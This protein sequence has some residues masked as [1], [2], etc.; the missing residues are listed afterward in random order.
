MRQFQS[1]VLLLVLLT[2][3]FFGQPVRAQSNDAEQIEDLLNQMEQ[4]VVAGDKDTYMT[5]IDQTDPVFALEHSRWA[6][7]WVEL[8]PIKRFDLV[9]DDLEISADAATAEL[10]MIWELQEDPRAQAATFAVNFRRNDAGQW[11]Y[12]GE[13]WA[14]VETENF[15]VRYVEGEGDIADRVVE[16]LPD[17]FSHTTT[18]LDYAPTNVNEIKLYDSREAL[19]ANTLLSLPPISGWNEPEEALKLY[20]GDM[21]A[22]RLQFVLVHEF[23]HKLTFD[24]ANNTHGY[25]SWW[26]EEGI[27]QYI[28]YQL[29]PDEDQD[30]YLLI[31][32]EWAQEDALADWD[33]ITDFANTPLDLWEYVYP[34]GYAM[35]RYVTETYGND[36]RNEWIRA[37]GGDMRLDEAT[38]TILGVEF[39]ALNAAFEDW[40][41]AK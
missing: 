3:T 5:Y 2:I 26:L 35:I 25:M 17:V 4:A 1:I 36:A 19:I 40:L 6:D 20:A 37:M 13:R 29:L 34:Q 22:G 16:M 9:V 33:Q 11:L 27:A 10:T 15:I 7:D 23:T 24:M 41:K 14:S 21:D 18:N 30:G 38:N 31:A 39:D 28:A 8:H 32:Q 12:A